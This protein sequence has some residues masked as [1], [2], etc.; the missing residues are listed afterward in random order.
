MPISEGDSVTLHYIGR[1]DDGSVFDTSLHKVAEETGLLAENPTRQFEPITIEIGD[2]NVI[3][4]LEEALT[5]LEEGETATISVAPDSAYGEYSEE[6]VGT[7][8]REAF[9]ELI[10]DHELREGFEVETDDGLP[11]RV[12][13]I[14]DEEVTV[15]FNNELAGERLTFELEILAVE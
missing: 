14:T 11:G 3:P 8:D 7:Y 15:D 12:T 10:G 6:R 5:G 13:A 2:E 9:E 4:G 1:L